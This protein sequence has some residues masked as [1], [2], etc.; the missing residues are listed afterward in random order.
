MHQEE[1][2]CNFTLIICLGEERRI[3]GIRLSI[4]LVWKCREEGGCLHMGLGPFEG[5]W[6]FSLHPPR[7]VLYPAQASLHCSGRVRE[8]ERASRNIPYV[9]GLSS[10]CPS[11]RL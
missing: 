2:V 9:K 6:D 11:P 5:S 3:E 10:I 1:E 4:R 8:L 7:Q